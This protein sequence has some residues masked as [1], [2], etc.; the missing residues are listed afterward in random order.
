MDTDI[1]G[2]GWKAAVGV[3]TFAQNTV[4]NTNDIIDGKFLVL[5]YPEQSENK[6]ILFLFS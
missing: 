1:S 2:F 4:V 6:S 3:G 5:A